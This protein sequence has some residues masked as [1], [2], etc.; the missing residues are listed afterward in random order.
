MVIKMNVIILNIIYLPRPWRI[1]IQT[2]CHLDM[3]IKVE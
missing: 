1:D 3:S 2:R